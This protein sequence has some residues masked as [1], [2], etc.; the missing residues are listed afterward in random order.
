[1]APGRGHGP[2]GAVQREDDVVAHDVKVPAQHRADVLVLHQHFVHLTLVAK[3]K[4]KKQNK[5]LRSRF[6]SME[7]TTDEGRGLTLERVTHL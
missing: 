6:R 2:L 5:V 4:Q 7:R 3:K 1:M